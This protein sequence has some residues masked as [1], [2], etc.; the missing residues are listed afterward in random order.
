VHT[1]TIVYKTVESH[2]IYA[3]IHWEDS[4]A[5]LPIIFFIHGGGLMMGSRT[6]IVPDELSLFV[7]SGYAVVSIDY[8]LAPETKLPE[9]IADVQDAA[10]WIR[11]NATQYAPVDLDRMA[12]VGQSSGGYLALLAGYVLTPRPK[13]IV[14][15]YGHGDF[16]WRCT[17]PGEAKNVFN[18]TFSR[19]DVEKCVGTPNISEDTDMDVRFPFYAYCL[20]SGEWINE[21]F[22]AD[23]RE[24]LDAYVQYCPVQNIDAEYP[25]TFLLHGDRD[26]LVPYSESQQMFEAL[27]D[28]GID[29]QF[30]LIPKAGHAF[31]SV[32]F[33]NKKVRACFDAVMEFLDHYCK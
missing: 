18:V 14:S 8:R 11:E 23:P 4:E 13:A 25:P 6:T 12:V 16:R 26:T 29:S 7:N 17:P 3:D 15:F 1:E 27:Q 22:G 19:E 28:A 21:V 30:Q 10:S 5:P 9:I 32:G 20:A 2:P 33:R 24:D 31:D